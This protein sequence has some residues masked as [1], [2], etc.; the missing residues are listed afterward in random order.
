MKLLLLLIPF[1]LLSLSV[2]AERPDT[3]KINQ[4]IQ[5]M[6]QDFISGI[7]DENECTR[8]RRETESLGDHIDFQLGNDW[9]HHFT[10]GEKTRL[11]QLRDEAYALHIF[12]YVVSGWSFEDLSIEDFH[13]ANERIHAEVETVK[14]ESICI[15]LIKVKINDYVA[16]FA[17]NE[18]PDEI[19]FNFAYDIER[20][21]GAGTKKVKGKTMELIL[22]N[23][24][25]DQAQL[26]EITQVMETSCN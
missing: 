25:F 13:L 16:Y 23:K 1:S 4:Q 18:G 21:N 24:K 12:I 19:R 8:L 6:V 9:T 2:Q 17:Q 7:E 20:F 11:K 14:Y 22:D 15:P 3:V 10:E 5:Q 26:S